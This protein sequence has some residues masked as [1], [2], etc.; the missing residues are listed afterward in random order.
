MNKSKP[1]GVTYNFPG[2]GEVNEIGCGE[3]L[4]SRAINQLDGTSLTYNETTQYMS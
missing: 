4:I 2:K 3:L 1:C